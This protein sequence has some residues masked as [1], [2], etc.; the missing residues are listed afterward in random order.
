MIGIVG[1]DYGSHF[2]LASQPHCRAAARIRKR[3]TP[4]FHPK[5]PC[6]IVQWELHVAACKGH[7]VIVIIQVTSGIVVDTDQKRFRSELRDF[8]S[9]VWSSTFY[10]HAQ[11]KA[12]VHKNVVQFWHDESEARDRT[13]RKVGLLTLVLTLGPGFLV[14][15]LLVC[16]YLHLARLEHYWYLVFLA[17]ATILAGL[18]LLYMVIF[19][20][21]TGKAPR[22]NE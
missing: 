6:S 15:G 13:K 21:R 19:G 4:F 18:P 22:H 11:L 14:L 9:G 12:E 10:T 2:N 17:V 16:E 20:L 5:K 7:Q 3:I 1:G 8:H